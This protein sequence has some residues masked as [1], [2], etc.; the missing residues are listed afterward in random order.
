[1]LQ[2]NRF[3]KLGAVALAVA[4]VATSSLEAQEREGERREGERRQ[5]QGRGGQ[6]G[7]GFFGGGFRGPG[8]GGVD[9]IGLVG[10]PQ[11]RTE[12]KI[13]EE[14]QAFIDELQ[15][16]HRTKSREIFSGIDF[17]SLRDKPEEERRKVME[18]RNAKR[19]K[20]VK[21]NEEV[22]AELLNNEQNK[23][24]NEIS[25]Q[26]RGIRAL[27]DDGVARQLDL[28]GEQKKKIQD[29]LAASDQERRKMFEEL[30]VGRRPQGGER[31]EGGRRPQRDFTAMREKME[32][33]RKKSDESVMAVLSSDQK[34]K[35]ASLKGKTFELNRGTFGRGRG[36]GGGGQ[37]GEGGRRRGENGG[38]GGDAGGDRPRRSAA[39]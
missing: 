22:L 24:L 23:R 30:G 1:M 5:G 2:M 11:I 29:A 15:A 20:L 35:F 3:L 39:E 28:S 17:A 36:Q 18:E 26:L 31:P 7:G 13:S 6:P 33:L 12:L 32:A 16:D 25:L 38:R 10:N 14:Q 34:S 8:G 27:T 4:F 9:K 19:Q 21:Q 37:G